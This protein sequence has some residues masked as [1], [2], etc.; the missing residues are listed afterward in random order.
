MDVSVISSSANKQAPVQELKLT[1]YVAFKK[2]D[3]FS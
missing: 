2:A 1:Y 3:T